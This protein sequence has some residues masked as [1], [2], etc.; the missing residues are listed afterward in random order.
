MSIDGDLGL[1]PWA[2]LLIVACILMYG[3][4]LAGKVLAR[5]GVNPALA[6]LLL[7]PF[8]Q[9]VAVWVFAYMRWPR[10]ENAK[11]QRQSPPASG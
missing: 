9:I 8:V 3:M 6:L 2:T 11:S 4:Y 10:Y 7:I 1:P 5:A